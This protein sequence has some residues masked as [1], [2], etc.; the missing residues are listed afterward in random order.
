MLSHCIFLRRAGSSARDGA[1]LLSLPPVPRDPGIRQFSPQA[2]TVF[3]AWRSQTVVLFGHLASR[4]CGGPTCSALSG[5]LV[6]VSAPSS[7]LAVSRASAFEPAPRAGRV[8]YLREP[9]RAPASRAGAC[10]IPERGIGAGGGPSGLGLTD[11]APSRPRFGTPPSPCLRTFSRP[12][13]QGSGSRLARSTW[14]PSGAPGSL[15]PVSPG[16]ADETTNWCL[17]P[18]L[19]HQGLLASRLA[20]ATR[21]AWQSMKPHIDVLAAFGLWPSSPTPFGLW[22]PSPTLL[23]LEVHVDV[24]YC[25]LR[26][27]PSSRATSCV[28]LSLRTCTVLGSPSGLPGRPA[29]LSAAWPSRERGALFF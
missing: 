13:A 18:S 19:H 9:S 8:E 3:G 6:R 5:T 29:P 2:V 10:G 21:P 22:S 15:P 14:C 7:F 12:F 16:L 28:F 4:L 23:C 27:R 1:R 20:W 11:L 26:W 17:K 25:P 24:L